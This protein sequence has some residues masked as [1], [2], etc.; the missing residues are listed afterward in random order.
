MPTRKAISIVILFCL[1]TALAVSP[2]AKHKFEQPLRL[3]SAHFLS[4]VLAPTN[5]NPQ[6]SR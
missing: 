4:S 5:F 1:A 2:N 6:V 3:P